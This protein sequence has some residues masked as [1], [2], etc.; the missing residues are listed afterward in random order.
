MSTSQLVR[1]SGVVLVF[2]GVLWGLGETAWGLFVNAADPSEYPQPTA[3]ILWIV[4]LAAFVCILL[5]L[6]GLYGAQ[7]RRARTLGLIG[8]VVL[9]LGEVLM[10]GLSWSG[11]FLQSANAD[12]IVEAEAA[13][14]TVAEPVMPLAGVLTAYGFH[15]LGWILFGVAALRA[16]VL[17]RWPVLLAMVAPLLL[18]LVAGAL[19]ASG[20]ALPVFVAPLPLVWTVGVAWLGVALA[21]LGREGE[22]AVGAAGAPSRELTRS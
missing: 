4:I 1:L 18:F 5:G 3:T 9:F 17:P 21:R 12:L 8:F 20:E 10:A 22:N 7:V 6:P 2:G 19:S 13:G 16:R 15:L 11:A 14:I